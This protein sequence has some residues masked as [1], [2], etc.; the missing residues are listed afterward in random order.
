MEVVARKKKKKGEV[1]D[2]SGGSVGTVCM[3]HF[4][5]DP[6]TGRWPSWSQI[7]L[8]GTLGP[9][10]IALE[11]K[12][13][14]AVNKDGSNLRTRLNRYMNQQN[15]DYF[16]LSREN[17]TGSVSGDVRVSPQE[18]VIAEKGHSEKQGSARSEMQGS[19]G[20][21][22]KRQSGVHTSGVHFGLEDDEFDDG[23]DEIFHSF[24]NDLLEQG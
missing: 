22:R 3:M 12:T 19:Q 15:R 18:G 1:R 11:K 14:N 7:M 8:G 13:K 6:Q 23:D 9:A 4:P 10:I 24:S 20:S 5:K 16:P 2:P 17:I 21:A